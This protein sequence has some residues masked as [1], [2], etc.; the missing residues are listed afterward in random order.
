MKI[1]HLSRKI[2]RSSDDIR[3]AGVIHDE[4][5]LE[6]VLWNDKLRQALII[7]F[8][9]CRIDHRPAKAR[10]QHSKRRSYREREDRVQR[11][12]LSGQT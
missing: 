1:L 12:S 4:L 5:R 10:V 3:M 8:H 11:L 6:N 9:R 7:D 2:A